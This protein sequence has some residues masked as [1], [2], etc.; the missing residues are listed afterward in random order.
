MLYRLIQK[1]PV[2]STILKISNAYVFEGDLR[3]MD[4]FAPLRLWLKSIGMPLL[5]AAILTYAVVH[6]FITFPHLKEILSEKCISMSCWF[7]AITPIFQPIEKP[8]DAPGA[9]IT[10][11]FPNLLGFGIGVYALLFALRPQ[12]LHD[13]HTHLARQVAQNK[14][15]QGTALMLNSSM[16]YPLIVMTLGLCPAAF[17][18]SFP[19][20]Q[21]LIVATWLCFWYGIAVVIEL[22]GILFSLSEHD[23]MDKIGL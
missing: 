4:H 16:A 15:K 13:F 14:R 10:S 12:W 21:S 11:V 9:L 5:V 23:T 7:H 6:Q 17:Q 3:A 18:Q 2:L 19:G 20:N 1:I 8:F 22:I